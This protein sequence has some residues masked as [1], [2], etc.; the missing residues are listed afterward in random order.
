[1]AVTFNLYLGGIFTILPSIFRTDWMNLGPIM[2][3]SIQTIISMNFAFNHVHM[4]YSV[5]SKVKQDHKKSEVS[6]MYVTHL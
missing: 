2:L 1:M 3:A 6:Q 5:K 4:S